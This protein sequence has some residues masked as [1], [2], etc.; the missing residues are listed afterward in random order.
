MYRCRIS[1]FFSR[2]ILPCRPSTEIAAQH[3]HNG[4]GIH[5]DNPLLDHSIAIL[6]LPAVGG[7]MNSFQESQEDGTACIPWRWFHCF[8][9]PFRIIAPKWPVFTTRRLLRCDPKVSSFSPWPS[10]GVSLQLPW[11][12]VAV[13]GSVALTSDRGPVRPTRHPPHPHQAGRS[14]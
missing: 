8:L 11:R 12:N 1:S 9:H 6:H 10:S 2:K 3:Q 13:P 14:A 4:K 7:T 5:D